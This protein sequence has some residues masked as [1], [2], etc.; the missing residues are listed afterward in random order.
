MKIARLESPDQ[1]TLTGLGG[2]PKKPVS[3]WANVY[4]FV[5]KANSVIGLLASCRTLRRSTSLQH[6]PNY[7]RSVITSEGVEPSL[8][9]ARSRRGS[10]SP[11]PPPALR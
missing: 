1:L 4:R 3:T 8:G 2:Q 10:S 7:V 6:P 5:D 9:V 11:R